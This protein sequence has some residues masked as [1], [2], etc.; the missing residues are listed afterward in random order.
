LLV[1]AAL[2]R[3]KSQHGNEYAEKSRGIAY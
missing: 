3:L 2:S 1:G